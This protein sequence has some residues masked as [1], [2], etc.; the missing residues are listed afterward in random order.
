MNNVLL[1]LVFSSGSISS[2]KRG[3]R[4][5]LMNTIWTAWHIE[6]INFNIFHIFEMY[7]VSP[8]MESITLLKTTLVAF[9]FSFH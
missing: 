7:V 4:S 5:F 3:V 8:S 1:V 2:F 6:Y 9:I